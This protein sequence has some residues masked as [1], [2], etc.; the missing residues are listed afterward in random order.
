MKTKILKRQKNWHIYANGKIAWAN[1]QVPKGFKVRLV[2]PS[3]QYHY[4][5]E[6]L[7][8]LIVYAYK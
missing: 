8:T 4:G 1:I 7:D 3:R 2:N 6:K 5:K